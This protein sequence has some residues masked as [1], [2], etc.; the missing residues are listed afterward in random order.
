VHTLKLHA[1]L[2][3]QGVNAFQDGPAAIKKPRKTGLLLLGPID[4][5]RHQ[6]VLR[7]F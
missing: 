3:P 7:T 4:L 6:H 1:L 2:L 5:W